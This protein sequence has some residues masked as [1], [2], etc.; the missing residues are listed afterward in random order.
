M[1]GLTLSHHDGAASA[2]AILRVQVKEFNSRP[3]LHLD[4]RPVFAAIN[5]AAAPRAD[6]W[7]FERQARFSREAGI[8][9]YAF[10][11]GKG[12]EWIG[13]GTSPGRF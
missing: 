1:A 7:D 6:G 10:D 13:P 8:H 11:A 4:D 2:P 3:V 5:R 9:V 12:V